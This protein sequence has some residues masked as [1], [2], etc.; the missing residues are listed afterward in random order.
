M[1]IEN[2]RA[3]L[4]AEA[5]AKD[6]DEVLAE[7]QRAWEDKLSLI[8]IQGGTEKQKTIFYTAL[9]RVFQ[10]PTRFQRCEWRVSGL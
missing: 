5:G 9:Y 10:M 4:E 3:N 1:S 2:A 8:K 7:A 6:F